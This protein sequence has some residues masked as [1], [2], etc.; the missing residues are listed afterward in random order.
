MIEAQKKSGAE[1]PVEAPAP[2]VLSP[3]RRAAPPAPLTGPYTPMESPVPRPTARPASIPERLPEE[4]ERIEEAV[5]GPSPPLFI[6]VE[7]YKE[8]LAYIQKLRSNA[9]GLRDAL[10]ALNEIQKEVETGLHTSQ[11]ALDSFN[12]ILGLLYEKLSRSKKPEKKPE[13]KPLPA[14]PRTPQEVETYAKEL[15]DEL[16]KL[17][18]NLKKVS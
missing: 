15:F 2:P 4:I 7:R 16:E 3:A 9:L 13:A 1:A 10:D 5:G 11:K 14:K 18:T 6:K 12:A 17:K 8:V